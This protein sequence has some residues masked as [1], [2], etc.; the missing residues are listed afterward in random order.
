MLDAWKGITEG[1]GAVIAAILTM[2]AAIIG[3]ALGSALFGR[4]VSD[5]KGAVEEAEKLLHGHK[6][7]VET[8]LG[9]IREKID[10]LDA[11]IA[12]LGAL[13]K[14]VADLDPQIAS[15]LQ[16]LGD[17]RGQL[18]D[19]QA[20]AHIETSDSQAS[21]N[22]E[23]IRDD[24]N[25]I[26]EKLEELAADPAIDGRTRAA[27]AR[28]DRRQYWMLI[29][30]L[31]RDGLLKGNAKQFRVALELWQRFKSGRAEP[32]QASLDRMSEIRKRVTE[33]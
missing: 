10:G 7:Q 6:E 20:A 11:Q 22:W 17:L 19:V 28:I 4:R 30:R 1:Q 3:V 18:S 15:A 31:H 26:K 21:G 27:Y 13:R 16:N 9:V 29:D 24:W 12:S 32:D 2:L 25:I 23:R 5:L 33:E 14:S 8:T